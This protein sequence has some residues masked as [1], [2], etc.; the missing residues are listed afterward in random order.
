MLSEF[1]CIWN[2]LVEKVNTGFDGNRKETFVGRKSNDTKTIASLN[3]DMV[4]FLTSTGDKLEVLEK[5]C[6]LLSKMNIDTVVCLMQ[7]ARTRLRIVL[8]IAVCQSKFRMSFYILESRDEPDS[9]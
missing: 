9:P 7:T 6:Q 2:E 5:H 1:H 3:S 4:V 8:Y